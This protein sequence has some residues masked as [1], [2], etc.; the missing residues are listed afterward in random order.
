MADKSDW[1]V[2]F[3]SEEGKRVLQDILEFSHVLQAPDY[4]PDINML[5]FKEGR[6]DVAMFILEKLNQDNFLE[7]IVNA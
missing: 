4:N 1:Q 2:V 3:G 5:A 7:L 6:R